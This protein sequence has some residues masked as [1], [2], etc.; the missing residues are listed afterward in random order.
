MLARVFPRKTNATPIDDYAFVGE[1]HLFTPED[2]TEVHISVA[3]T[4]D[5]KEA[6]RLEK[7]WKRIAPVQMGGPAFLQSGGEFEVGKYLKKG[8]VITSR[9]CPNKCWFCAVWKRE[10]GLKELE[11]KDGHNIRDD[12]ILACSEQ[13]ILDVFEMLKRQKQRA[14]FSGGL[15]AKLL[16]TWHIDKLAEIKAER[17][18]FAYDSDRDLEPLI[19][20]SKMLQAR[21]DWYRWRKCGCYVL[22]GYPNDTIEKAE[23]RL[24]TTLKL[25]FSPCA[26][27]YRDPE[28]KNI[29][30]KEWGKLQ[31]Q[32]VRNPI[33]AT[34]RK[35]LGIKRRGN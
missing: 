13:H 34:T 7:S 35:K 28:D 31:R 8:D 9:G 14:V 4:W 27:F 30:S 3:F 20:A 5:M 33:I 10:N 11:I 2:I 16:K 22:M 21:D 12:N 15:E 32:W 23:E 29:K 18:Y 6:E 19:E 24:I 17:V 26:M 1:P 25:G